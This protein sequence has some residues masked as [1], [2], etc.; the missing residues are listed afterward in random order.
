MRYVE[1]VRGRVQHVLPADLATGYKV[2]P[3]NAVEISLSADVRD[4]DVYDGKT[5]T[6]PDQQVEE[7]DQPAAL[8]PEEQAELDLRLAQTTVDFYA[9]RSATLA[10]VQSVEAR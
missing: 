4:G 3:R 8:T 7:A 10:T 5:F 6:R 1:V 9:E 2:L